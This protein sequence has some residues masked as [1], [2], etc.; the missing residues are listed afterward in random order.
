MPGGWYPL[1]KAGW[2]IPSGTNS[3]PVVPTIYRK[4]LKYLGSYRRIYSFCFWTTTV[5]DEGFFRNASLC[6]KLDIYDYMEQK[7][8]V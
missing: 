6:S 3:P 7:W 8:N 4:K 1:A 5:P 2:V